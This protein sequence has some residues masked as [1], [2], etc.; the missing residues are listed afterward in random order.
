MTEIWHPFN[1]IIGAYTLRD[2]IFNG[3]SLEIKIDSIDD[4]DDERNILSFDFFD[5]ICYIVTD[6][7]HYMKRNK[8]EEWNLTPGTF[9]EIENSLLRDSVLKNSYCNVNVKIRH[10]ALYLIDHVI[11]I[12][13]TTPPNIR[14][15]INIINPI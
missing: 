4:D 3:S 11:E 10:Y 14:N 13:A 9:Y 15:G 1:K 2:I 7:Y 6:E 8:D 12:I 5:V